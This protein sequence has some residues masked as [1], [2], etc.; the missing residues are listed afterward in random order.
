MALRDY[1]FLLKID[2]GVHLKNYADRMKF[3]EQ[4]QVNINSYIVGKLN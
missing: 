2:S 4:N 1:E 3:D